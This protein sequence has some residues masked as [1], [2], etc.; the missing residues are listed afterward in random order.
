MFNL[1]RNNKRLMQIVLALVTLPFA[2]WGID[3]YQRVMS[4][5]GEVAEVGG[6]KITEQEF[7]D[8][9]RQQQER[10]RGLLGRNFDPALFDSPTI[11]MEVLEG[12]ISQRL[13][14]RHAARNH[15]TVSS[16]TLIETT[17]AIP[18][19]QI[20]G[21]FS[22]ER[23]DAALRNERMSPEVFDAALRRDLLVQQLTGALAD[24]GL[25]SKAVSRQFAQLRAQQ[26]EI[27]E[28][29]VQADA[30]LVQ[31]KI[32]GDAIRAVY[33]ASPGRFQ[34]PEEVGVEYIALSTDALLASE[35]VGADEIKSYYESNIS[36]YGE[37]EQRR[38]SHI[39]IA[40]KS[41]AGEAEKAKARVPA[42][43]E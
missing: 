32:T 21:K 37:P 29:R 7:G 12:L 22:R 4:R 10:L 11:R 17:M 27:A 5:A 25:A 33:D 26:R 3:S 39:L 34:V 13:L 41:G 38:A 2:F 15:L 35:Q 1:V 14:M 9:M 6:Q 23:Y 30:Q 19:F 20:D 28:Y 31:P 40:V 24:S 8:A 36:K 18:A 43:A 42:Q 16:E